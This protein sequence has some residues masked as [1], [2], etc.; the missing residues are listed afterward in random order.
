MAGKTIKKKA[1]V[2]LD[3]YDR[4]DFSAVG[5][6]DASVDPVDPEVQS[7]LNVALGKGFAYY[8]YNGSSK[9]SKKW[10]VAF[11]KEQKVDKNTLAMV[12]KARDMDV[13]P[14]IGA[15]CRM[16]SDDNCPV[17]PTLLGKVQAAVD[18]IVAL[19][20]PDEEEVTTAAPVI[21]IHERM[22]NKVR[23]FMGESIEGEI[24]AMF[25]AKGKSEFS[26]AKL[27]DAEQIA[28][29][30]AQI[31][32]D[33]YREDRD[34]IAELVN[35]GA[36]KSDE[37]AQ[38]KEAYPHSAAMMKRVLA[39]FEM[40]VSDAE[41]HANKTKAVRKATRKTTVR[42]KKEKPLEKQVAGIKYKA[43]DADL[44]LVSESPTKIIGAKEV[45]F[46]H[47][48]YRKIG[49]IVAKDADMGGALGVKGASIVGIDDNKNVMKTVRKP[50]EVLKEFK[51]AGKVKLRK[52]MDGINSVGTKFPGR[53]NEHM[54][55]L[56]IIT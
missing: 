17:T 9:D 49:H 32:A 23:D 33:T 51:G 19:V 22:V 28:P 39:F 43:Q 30:Q 36:K 50:A 3:P 15:L 5:I 31:I 1:G 26:L 40:L 2:L 14:T 20:G 12:R 38:L 41:H 10:M 47:T 42:K 53:T 37:I 8:S 46:Y 35:A 25:K 55:F 6:V 34:E 44:K 29:K 52:F 54:V 24:D 11:L 18:K 21:S 27:L 13:S 7:R 4:P 48:K 45:W 56:K 16:M